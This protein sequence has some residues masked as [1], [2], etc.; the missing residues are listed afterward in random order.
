MHIRSFQ[1]PF[2]QIF[3]FSGTPFSISKTIIGQ[4]NG[5]SVQRFDQRIEVLVIHSW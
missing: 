5:L 3:M 4:N 2:L 1:V